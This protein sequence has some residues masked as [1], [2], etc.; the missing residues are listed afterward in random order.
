MVE[1]NTSV[2]G[3]KLRASQRDRRV[4]LRANHRRVREVLG[5]QLGKPQRAVLLV[6][7]GSPTWRGLFQEGGL[8]D[9]SQPE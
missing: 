7:L 3:C 6:A 2:A 9:H 1:R 4:A 5:S 8:Q